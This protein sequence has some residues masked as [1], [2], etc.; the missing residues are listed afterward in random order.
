MGTIIINILTS[1]GFPLATL[2][3]GFLIGHRLAIGRDKRNDFNKAAADFREAF[4]PEAT[5]LKHN[6]NV[7]GLSSSNTLHGKLRNAYL[8]QLKALE[9][10][11]GYLSPAKITAM[12]RAWDEYCHPNGIPQDPN[13][14][15]DFRFNAYLEIEDAEGAAKAKEVALQ[16][17]YKILKVADFK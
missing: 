4:L 5:F 16:K 2:L 13:E 9:V 12:D 1:P 17:I 10:F 3:L 7:G 6:A 11:K 14:K 15:R 8:R